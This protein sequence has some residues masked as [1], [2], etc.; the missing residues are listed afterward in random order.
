MKNIKKYMTVIVTLAIV[1]SAIVFLIPFP[2]SSNIVF[3]VTW[4]MGLVSIV[5][6]LFFA[7]VAFNN[8]SLKSKIFGYP[9][10]RVG[11]IYLLLQMS[12]TLIS[13]IVGAFVEIPLWI[14][15][16]VDL[17]V[18]AFAIIGTIFTEAY[19]D[20][21]EKIDQNAPLTTKFIY[22]LRVDVK[23]LI[24]RNTNKELETNLNV[25]LEEVIYSDP[26]TSDALLEIEDEINRKYIELK[27]QVLENNYT[28]ALKSINLLINLVQER[29][30]RCKLGKK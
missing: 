21:I 26:V 28:E 17:I 13:F 6:Q 1:Y 15:F 18:L 20:E 4:L 5:A 30:L 10:F 3:I 19:R 7:K 2:H 24:N 14:V 16:V 9:I 27:E 22:D 11:I 12:V 29:N 8:N 23:A 25:L